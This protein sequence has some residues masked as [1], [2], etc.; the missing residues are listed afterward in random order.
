MHV[1]GDLGRDQYYC[2]LFCEVQIQ[3]YFNFLFGL[4]GRLDCE[5]LRFLGMNLDL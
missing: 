3:V 4:P 2:E 5:L 1:H